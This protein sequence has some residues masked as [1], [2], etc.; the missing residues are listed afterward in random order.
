MARLTDDDK[1]FGKYITYGKKTSSEN[2]TK[3]VYSSSYNEDYPDDKHN[4]L[5]IVMFGWIIQFLLPQ[6]IK[7]LQ[8]KVHAT[9]WDAATIA[10][11]GRDYYFVYFNRRYGFSKFDTLFQLFYGVQGDYDSNFQNAGLKEKSISWFLP[12]LDYRHVKH[13]MFD[14]NGQLIWQ[15][16]QSNTSEARQHN[17]TKYVLSQT[18]N[19]RSYKVL[20][21][22]GEIIVVDVH[23]EYRE[24]KRGT[25]WC[26]WL[27]LFMDGIKKH[28]IEL[29]FR[30]EIGHRKGSWKG[31]LVGLGYE[32]SYP[33]E[34]IDIAVERFFKDKSKSDHRD[35][36]G[37]KLLGR[38]PS[39][40]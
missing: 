21:T 27:S 26:K 19:K 8:V 9:S 30:S 35:L 31:G 29:N 5:T 10:R 6:F 39:C 14:G 3:I 38:V 13:Q 15:E 34:D 24:W 37:V 40:E 4:T 11:L 12:W 17:D 20:D 2:Y 22:D 16:D 36:K 18:M 32:L 7:P 33:D 23:S 25:S 1:Q 28:T